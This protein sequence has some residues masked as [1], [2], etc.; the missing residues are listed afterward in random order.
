M[1]LNFGHN[2]CLWVFK[3]PRQ[4]GNIF[5]FPKAIF[6]N[7]CKC[8]FQDKQN[9]IHFHI[10]WH[11]RWWRLELMKI[12]SDRI[13]I[14]NFYN[15]GN[16]AVN[17]V[18]RPDLSGCLFPWLR[19]RV[20]FGFNALFCPVCHDGIPRAC[21]FPLPP[22]EQLYAS[23]SS[24]LWYA[25]ICFYGFGLAFAFI[26]WLFFINFILCFNFGR[27]HTF[28]FIL[29][30]LYGFSERKSSEWNAQGRR[31]SLILFLFEF[32]WSLSFVVRSSS[33]ILSTAD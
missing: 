19:L 31:C 9:E 18:G 32:S 23:T 21:G 17:V 25:N 16:F 6:M 11:R 26:S 2:D 1:Q 12:S 4:Q 27:S 29:F 20:R 3:L 13:C 22:S 8:C 10:L 15:L 33:F 28:W 14:K 30:R 5:N 7:P 24:N